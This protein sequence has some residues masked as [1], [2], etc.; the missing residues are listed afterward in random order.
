MSQSG[1]YDLLAS[2]C[3]WS[4]KEAIE[5]RRI[6]VDPSNFPCKAIAI[7]A[8]INSFS[9]SF[10]K[11]DFCRLFPVRASI[12][13]K[14]PEAWVNIIKAYLKTK[15]EIQSVGRDVLGFSDGFEIMFDS[16]S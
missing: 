5:C 4:G 10:H 9:K 8:K 6:K 1:S 3:Y 14:S 16:C 12:E 7:F 11:K 15:R 13:N 2:A